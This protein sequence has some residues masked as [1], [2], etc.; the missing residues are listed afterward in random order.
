MNQPLKVQQKSSKL[1]SKW[2]RKPKGSHLAKHLPLHAPTIDR[3][4]I[5][6]KVISRKNALNILSCYVRVDNNRVVNILSQQGCQ[7]L[8][9]SQQ[10][11]QQLC[12]SKQGW[13]HLCLSK[14]G[15]QAFNNHITKCILL[16]TI[17]SDYWIALSIRYRLF[18]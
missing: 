5:F 2:I 17:K 7:Q 1:L 15:C 3:S 18:T 9:L 13:Q 14:Q 4:R 10:G 8:C 16:R 11:C 6:C 12:L